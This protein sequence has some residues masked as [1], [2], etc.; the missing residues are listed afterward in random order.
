[1]YSVTYGVQDDND[2]DEGEPVATLSHAEPSSL[3][4]LPDPDLLYPKRARR[5]TSS[6]AG[7]APD[8][9]RGAPGAD[10]TDEEGEWEEEEEETETTDEEREWG[11]QA[12]GRPANSPHSNSVSDPDDDGDEDEEDDETLEEDEAVPRQS[13]RVPAKQTGAGKAQAKDGK[14]IRAEAAGPRARGRHDLQSDQMLAL[15]LLRRPP[16]SIGNSS[17]NVKINK[18]SRTRPHAALL[19]SKASS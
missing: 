18:N 13:K 15:A 8:A 12:G 3:D 14:R 6:G 17:S 7:A 4:L 9:R 2:A 19:S 1:M 10:D 5:S 16:A 11:L